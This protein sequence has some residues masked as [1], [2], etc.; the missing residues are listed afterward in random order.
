MVMLSLPLETLAYHFTHNNSSMI[1]IEELDL[2]AL[3]IEYE[4][5]TK[6]TQKEKHFKL[7]DGSYL[8]VQYD[9]PVHFLSEEGTWREFDN[10]L[11]FEGKE[12]SNDFT[13]YVNAEGDF[14]TKFTS[15]ANSTILFKISDIN[16]ENTISFE[17]NEADV[18]D[19]PG[20]VL[21]NVEVLSSNDEDSEETSILEQNKEILTLENLSSQIDY[22][23]VFEDVDFQYIVTTTGV[24]ENII[25]N[26]KRDNYDFSFILNTGSLVAIQNEDGSISINSET[27][28]KYI[29]PAP[30]MYDNAGIRSDSVNYTLNM[31]AEGKYELSIDAAEE[32]INDSDRAFPVTIDPV[33]TTI[34]D[35]YAELY[36]ASVSPTGNEANGAIN[37]GKDANN[38]TSRT[39]VNW[40][41][42]PYLKAYD[43]VVSAQLYY[44][45]DSNSSS[46]VVVEAHR[47]SANWTSGTITWGNKPSVEDTVLDYTSISDIGDSE[48]LVWDITNVAHE[49]Y[50]TGESNGIALVASNAGST[51]V[52]SLKDDAENE[53]YILVQ[54]RCQ[55]GIEDNYT[56]TTLESGTSG[57][58]YINNYTGT[59]TYIYDMFDSES[60]SMPI[61]LDL[62][63]NSAIS[64][65]RFSGRDYMNTCMYDNMILCDGWKL[66]AQETIVPIEILEMGLLETEYDYAYIYC[67]RDGTEHYFYLDTA[68]ADDSASESSESTDQVKYVD[69]SGLGMTLVY[70]EADNQYVITFHD[71][72]KKVFKI[73]SEERRYSEV[74]AN[75]YIVSESDSNGNTINYTYDSTYPTRLISIEDP[76]GYTITL[77]YDANGYFNKVTAGERVITLGFEYGWGN[78]I[79]AYDFINDSYG[80]T[81]NFS[82]GQAHSILTTITSADGAVTSLDYEPASHFEYCY[83][84]K[85]ASWKSGPAATANT[86]EFTYDR[87]HA[88]TVHY[89]GTDCVNC[90]DTTSTDDIYMTYTFDKWGNTTLIYAEDY[91]RENVYSTS[92]YG[93]ASGNTMNLSKANFNLTTYADTGVVGNNLI[94]GGSVEDTTAN[95]TGTSGA[96]AA[97]TGA[98]SYVGNKSIR[99][100]VTNSNS[101]LDGVKKSIHLTPGEYCFSVNVKCID[102][103]AGDL[104][105]AVNK[106]DG[107]RIAT[108]ESI[109]K[110]I[111][112]ANNGWQKLYLDFVVEESADYL[113]YVGMEGGKGTFY[114]DGFQLE[115][116]SESSYSAFNMIDNSGFEASGNWTFNNA[117]ITTDVNKVKFGDKAVK[118]NEDMNTAASVSQ[119]ITIG[120][121]PENSY[122][123]S[124]WAQADSIP[125]EAHYVNPTE[126]NQSPPNATF[127]LFAEVNYTYIN[128]EGSTV[129]GV[130]KTS[131]PFTWET[132]EWQY[133]S[134]VV[135]L[136]E[137]TEIE[138]I[139]SI[140]SITVGASYNYNCN[141]AMFDNI[142]L[143][144]D[145]ALRISYDENGS[146]SSLKVDNEDT[147][148]YI[149][150]ENGNLEEVKDQNKTTVE[151]YSYYENGD[152]KTSWNKEDNRE[153]YYYYENSK[154]ISVKDK[155]D[156]EIESYKYYPDG[157]LEIAITEDSTSR[158][159]YTSWGETTSSATTIT[160]NGVEKTMASSSVYD[161]ATRLL[162]SETDSLGNTTTYEYNADKWLTFIEDANGNQTKYNYSSGK[163]TNEYS[164]FDKDGVLDEG[165]ATIAYSYDIYGRL[166][167]VTTATTEYVFAYNGANLLQSVAIEG[168]S[169]PLITYRYNENYSA[170]T[171]VTYANGLTIDYV[172]DTLGNVIE[173]KR[174]GTTAL[175]YIYNGNM[176]VVCEKDHV[177]DSVIEYQYTDGGE[178]Y[179][180]KKTQNGIEILEYADTSI[181]NTSKSI[182][183]I[184][185]YELDY[186]SIYDEETET[187]KYVLPTDAELTSDTDAFGRTENVYLKDSDGSNTLT[188]TYTYIDKAIDG[189]LRT[190]DRIQSITY[191]TNES[192]AYTYD[193][194][195]NITSVSDGPYIITYEYDELYQLT[196]EN[197]QKAGK[198]WAYTYDKS[199]NILS[200]SEYSYTAKGATLGTA[201]DTITYTYGNEDWGDQLTAY[202]GT[203][204]TYDAQGNPLNW[205]DG[206]SFSWTGRQLDSITKSDGTV[207]SFTYD[208]NGMRTEK[209]V[210]DEIYAYVWQDGKLIAESYEYD[211]EDT[212]YYI[213][214]ENGSP[215]A[216]SYLDEYYYYIK[217]QQGDIL[218]FTDSEGNVV[219]TYEYDAWGNLLSYTGTSYLAEYN[220]LRYRGYAYD[221]ETGFYY[222]QSRYYDPKAGRFL[223]ADDTDYLGA[224]GTVLGYNLYAYCENDTPNYSDQFG[225][226]RIAVFYD[227]RSSYG[228]NGFY[229]QAQ[230]WIKHYKKFDHKVLSLGYTSIQQFINKWNN[231]A[232]SNKTYD[233]VVIIGHGD[234]GSLDCNQQRLLAEGLY[235]RQFLIYRPYDLKKMP[236]KSV[237][238]FSCHGATVGRSSTLSIAQILAN[239]TGGKVIAVKDGKVNI[240]A[241]NGAVSK[242]GGKWVSVKYNSAYAK[243]YISN[244][245]LST[246]GPCIF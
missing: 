44:K 217:N 209:I 220:S 212:Q 149:Y 205:R 7:S 208:A 130:E 93:Y 78:W 187:S 94:I 186:S 105:L 39:Y 63:Y 112:K 83:R 215:V 3:T 221:V 226:L 12:D 38:E 82:Y 233:I 194:V 13:G 200:K 227:S 21:E 71:D 160:I 55:N 202:D 150:D 241:S 222:L 40:T 179:L 54:Y 98:E 115:E 127:E 47:V 192:Y 45:Y 195:G 162:K 29:I 74:F 61:D 97:I 24:K 1:E 139:V 111:S 116:K 232:A 236:A 58:T 145:S 213:Y 244:L 85:T 99:C 168:E 142:S 240:R 230:C 84:V 16:N 79:E 80:S 49:W 173:V 92:I 189:E 73:V 46:E 76:S 170:N 107:T 126:E 214:D 191:S 53:P 10:A 33:V 159:S 120:T 30:F 42:L 178:L 20:C 133:V 14:K 4:D 36:T 128:L 102:G 153:L 52:V 229:S 26:G 158:Y 216:W 148:E 88:T 23:E 136:P 17:L 70:N 193:A 100:V 6:R 177:N 197:N 110:T 176:Q 19:V 231:A 41:E 137:N 219:V 174:N 28:T 108:S 161:E 121:L 175:E 190:S 147:Y 141:T 245:S 180:T 163:L 210:G 188:V 101:N 203:V 124:G 22:E 196:R 183:V 167:G 246:F 51:G 15:K 69:E 123:L 48:Y 34:T 60:S 207:V 237:Y 18:N 198:T 25:V 223:N 211:P 243:Y 185:G 104:L 155:D 135:E 75:G 151:K 57:N 131:I 9:E 118:V 35:G 125:I 140:D 103:V 32:W 106:A 64:D 59:L 11:S 181:E 56:Y 2:N 204:T 96:I 90:V 89:Y 72:S 201:I 66:S 242:K 206:M 5:E 199:G 169:N 172:Y 43:K 67:D 119:T 238:L 218:G 86:A 65:C 129:S 132:D 37:I 224:S 68:E 154:L 113:L 166:T 234:A 152:L 143:V 164:D 171:G 235:D 182:T 239:K 114:A 27:E 184:N 95:I 138:T 225:N 62:I 157:N 156:N 117:S 50:E 228:G 81:T 144:Q 87:S 165:E 77:G 8:A 146:I 109:N 122:I 91:C 31:I 134:G